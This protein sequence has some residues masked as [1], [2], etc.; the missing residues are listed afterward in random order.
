MTWSSAE[1]VAH[2]RQAFKTSKKT[3]PKKLS[4]LAPEDSPYGIVE[5][6]QGKKRSVKRSSK[7]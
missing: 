3:M 2:D 5:K 4:K 6:S 1:S 7:R